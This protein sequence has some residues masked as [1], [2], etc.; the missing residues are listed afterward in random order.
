MYASL[1]S[2]YSLKDR[3]K[4]SH[5]QP[6]I[7]YSKFY[8]KVNLI[9]ELNNLGISFH[10][11]K[12]L[13]VD[14]VLKYNFIIVTYLVRFDHKNILPVLQDTQWLVPSRTA[15]RCLEVIEK[16]KMMILGVNAFT[17][18]RQ[19]QIG[20]LP[21]HEL[22]LD[23]LIKTHGNH[24]PIFCALFDNFPEGNTEALVEKCVAAASNFLYNLNSKKPKNV[25]YIS[26]VTTE[27]WYG[28]EEGGPVVDGEE[29]EDVEFVIQNDEQTDKVLL[30]LSESFFQY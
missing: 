28:E 16:N 17:V 3:K 1:P 19:K 11:F 29:D 9:P 20:A 13:S 30:S 4:V 21:E 7:E 6:I 22:D 8:F 24:I 26:F 27:N 14:L 23:H 15:R 5:L 25:D 12:L 18:D 10:D 2:I